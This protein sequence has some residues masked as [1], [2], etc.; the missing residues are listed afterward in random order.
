MA[1]ELTIRA[2]G[3]AE[4]AYTGA[5]GWHG[6]GNEL[7][8]GATIEQWIQA[9]GM[10]WHIRRAVARYF[11]DPEGSNDCSMLLPM[12][13]KS[14]LFRSDNL[15]PLGMVSPDYQIVQPAQVLEFFRDL[16]SDHG[17]TLETAG[18][19]FGGKKFWALAKIA[20]QAVVPG[21]MVGGYL[22][23][24]TSADGSMATEA[25]QTTIRVVC[26][27]TLRAAKMEDGSA[28]PVVKL[29][30]RSAFCDQ[31]VKAQL[32]LSR[33]NFER[34]MEA[35]RRLAAVPVSNLDAADF[36]R[37]L[38]RPEEHAAKVKADATRAQ[39]A[40]AARIAEEQAATGENPFA[41]LMARTLSP[42]AV[43]A[44][45]QA[46]S[47]EEKAKRA[48]KGE[49]KILELFAGAAIGNALPGAGGTAWG[50]V[51]AVTEYFD[52]HASAKSADHRQSAAMFGDSDKVKETAYQMALTRFAS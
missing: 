31:K 17:M 28:A 2:N 12:D 20:E 43:E 37:Q 51:N 48:P 21:D 24:S 19:L 9:A 40:D 42:V 3:A 7:A 30:H 13:E 22:L 14:I 5:K 46:S 33:E 26:N 39:I 27:N 44:S 41:S 36:V 38:L 4:M 47:A 45:A 8:A 49:G 29:S 23:L 25:R 16:V 1:H 15:T 50:L 10:D 35:L 18:T 52:H 6:L 11:A 32:G 34:G